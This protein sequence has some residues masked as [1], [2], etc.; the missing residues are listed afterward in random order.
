MEPVFVG[1]AVRVGE[2]DD[3]A[4]GGGDAR[5]ARHAE[6]EVS[7]V[8]EI[9]SGRIVTK[10]FAKTSAVIARTVH[11]VYDGGTH[12]SFV[13]TPITDVVRPYG[14][15]GLVYIAAMPEEF[16]MA[17]ENAL[18][19]DPARRRA[20][21]EDFLSHISWNKT[22]REM[23]ELIEEVIAKAAGKKTAAYI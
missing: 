2:R 6:A 3:F 7:F 11:F 22:Q 16:V 19:E 12:E 18:A 15:E 10:V 20:K 14:E 23:S 21:T 9:A 1:P 17:I 8:S 13:S 5:V 4:G